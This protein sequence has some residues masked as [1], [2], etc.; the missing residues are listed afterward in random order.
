MASL[1]ADKYGL[2]VLAI[3]I[4]YVGE[5]AIDERRVHTWTSPRD[6]AQLIKIGLRYPNLGFQLVYGVS[7]TPACFFDNINAEKLGYRPQD[8]VHQHLSSPELIHP[9][10]EQERIEA[11]YIGGHFVT[12]HLELKASEQA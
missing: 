4:G 10:P 3:R 1:Y 12:R 6:L 2:H 8:D 11:R 7:K 9:S 5:V